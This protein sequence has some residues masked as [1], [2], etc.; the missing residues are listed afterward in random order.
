MKEWEPDSDEN[1]IHDF[2]QIKTTLKFRLS[3][4]RMAI[5][6]NTNNNKCWGR[7]GEKGTL[8]PAGGNINLYN[9]NRKQYG[10]SSKN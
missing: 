8:N 4:A 9:H 7:C 10:D 1:K 2:L 5:I 6:K 3:P